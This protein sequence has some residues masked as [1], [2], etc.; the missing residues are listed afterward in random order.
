MSTR[1]NFGKRWSVFN[2]FWVQDQKL[3]HM[4]QLYLGNKILKTETYKLRSEL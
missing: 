3:L 2:K 1:W 4:V